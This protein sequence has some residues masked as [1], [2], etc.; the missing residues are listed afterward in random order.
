LLNEIEQTIDRTIARARQIVG[1]TGRILM[2]TQYNALARSGCAAPEVVALGNIT[3]EGLPGSLLE[4]GLNDRI[5][6][7]AAKYGAQVFDLFGPL[8]FN[9]NTLVSSDCV[10]PNGA[11]YQVI[12]ALAEAAFL[13]GP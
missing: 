10:H 12:L 1:P 7:I 4:R 11:G 5:R 6:S 3:L 2:R 8:T 13:A 9:A